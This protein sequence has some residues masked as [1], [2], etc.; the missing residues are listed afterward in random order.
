MNI[1]NKT[2]IHGYSLLID[3]NDGECQMVIVSS[4]GQD[5]K[6]RIVSVAAEVDGGLK[7]ST[8]V[9]IPESG[10]YTYLQL[11]LRK[12]VCAGISPSSDDKA[13]EYSKIDRC[14]KKCQKVGIIL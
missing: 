3:A 5:G 6:I 7:T 8:V 10:A 2:S 9:T 13:V 11:L 1:I 14:L 4:G 12:W